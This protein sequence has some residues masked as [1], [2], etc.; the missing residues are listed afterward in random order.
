MTGWRSRVSRAALAGGVGFGA[1]AVALG[2]AFA[3]ER[4]L[5]VPIKFIGLGE[6][7]DDLIAFDPDAYVGALLGEA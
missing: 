1:G 7:V 4:R 2:V 5:G 6:G 3:V